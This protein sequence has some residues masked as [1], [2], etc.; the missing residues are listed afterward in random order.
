MG[1]VIPI[2]TKKADPVAKPHGCSSLR[3][4]IKNME[5]ALSEQADVFATYQEIN[6]NLGENIRLL[7]MNYI[8]F[9][10]ALETA[11]GTTRRLRKKA[12]RL[13]AIMDDA[14]D[15]NRHLRQA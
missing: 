9:G 13:A 15:R 12:L 7:E 2:F 5:T 4:A 8:R 10:Q 1:T 14:L 6:K 11:K 3:R